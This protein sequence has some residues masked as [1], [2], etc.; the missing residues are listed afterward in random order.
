M[1]YRTSDTCAAIEFDGHRDGFGRDV[2]S[3][4]R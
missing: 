4:C 3:G 1:G 2:W